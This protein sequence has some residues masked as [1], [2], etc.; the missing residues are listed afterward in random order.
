MK[1]SRRQAAQRV[2]AFLAEIGL[3]VVVEPGANGFVPGVALGRGRLHVDEDTVE[4]G[5]LLHEA[6]QVSVLPARFR[7]LADGDIGE[8]QKAMF[9]ALRAED[10]DL[11]G[12][13]WRRALQCC[14]PEATAWAWAAGLHLG[15]HSRDIIAG[16]A[17]GGE[18]DD[19]RTSLQLRAYCGIN[20][21]FHAGMCVASRTLASSLNVEPFPAMSRWVQ[22]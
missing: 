14:D 16:K 8:A 3:E 9:K 4:V 6:G 18:G 5:D 22:V 11:Q 17:Y 7:H 13:E 12:L 2:R 10:A 21:L 15:I 1:R 20:G 19:V